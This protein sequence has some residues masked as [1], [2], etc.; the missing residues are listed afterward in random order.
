[1]TRCRA[2]GHPLNQFFSLGTMP[3]VNAFLTKEE[4]KHE[5]TYELSI[6]FCKKCYLVQLMQALDAERLFKH[7]L[8]FSSATESIVA[9]SKKTSDHLIRKLSLKPESFIIE[10]GSNDGVNLRFYKER[11]MNVLGIDPAENIAAVAQKYAIPTMTR[12]FNKS[13]SSELV[14]QGIRADLL[15]GA[16]VF[17]HIP[18]IVDCV[19]AVKILLK[20]G[21]S[22]VFESAYIG[23]LFENK[24]DMIYH[25]HVFYY[26]LVALQN[27]FVHAGLTIYDCEFTPMH[28]G[29]LR[30]YVCHPGAFPVSGRVA[31]VVRSERQ[32][33]YNTI[34]PYRRIGTQVQALRRKLTT[35]LASLRKRKKRIAAYGASAKGMV[36]LNYFQIHTF[37]DFIADKSEAKQGLYTPGT[38]LHIYPPAKVFTDHPD[39]VLI[40]AWN[41]AD[42]VMEFLS[43]YRKAG[44]KFII[45]FPELVIV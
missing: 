26:S 30:V 14:A 18:T 23:G 10:I 3:P 22:A 19:K 41:I 6:G 40:L 20:K 35:L 28:G 38:H 25:E 31:G 37:L 4:M 15:Y 36:L 16:N 8:Y 27:L 24:F 44:G 12:F 5:R 34:S 9:H 39:Y 1:M 17:A 13:L 7:Y 11:G 33:G 42:E 32:R 29:S 45:P 2:C 43:E 21:G